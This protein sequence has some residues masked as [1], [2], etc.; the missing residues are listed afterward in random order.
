M[1]M[2]ACRC[3]IFALEPQACLLCVFLPFASISVH[4]VSHQVQNN[5]GL[6]PCRSLGSREKLFSFKKLVFA[7]RETS[8]PMPHSFCLIEREIDK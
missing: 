7:T 5:T 4:G 2:M 8:P 1:K 6:I 3:V